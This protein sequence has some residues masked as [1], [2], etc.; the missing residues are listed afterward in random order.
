MNSATITAEGYPV[1]TAHETSFALTRHEQRIAEG[2]AAGA[3]VLQHVQANAPQDAI[4]RASAF[5]FEVPAPGPEGQ[6]KLAL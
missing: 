5:G 4:V 3:H 2:R 1:S 6:F